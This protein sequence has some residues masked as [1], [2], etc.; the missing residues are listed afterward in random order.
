MHAD[1][2]FNRIKMEGLLI[3]MDQLG[4]EE[5]AFQMLEKTIGKAKNEKKL[6]EAREIGLLVGQFLM[7]KV[8]AHVVLCML[9]LWENVRCSYR[10]VSQCVIPLYERIPFW[11]VLVQV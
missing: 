6:Q 9:H 7:L 3:V 2:V 5:Q 1:T 8:C 10:S 4:E 11:I